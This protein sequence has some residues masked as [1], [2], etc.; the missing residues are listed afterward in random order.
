MSCACLSAILTAILLWGDHEPVPVSRPTVLIT[1]T[2]YAYT[3]FCKG[4]TDER[5]RYRDAVAAHGGLVLEVSPSMP[6]DE[7]DRRITAAD[8]ILVPGGGD[9]DPDFYHE[10]PHPKLGNVDEALDQLEFKV[11]KAA[12]DRRL[13]AL[14]ICRGM[15]VLNVFYG[16]TLIQDI[17][18][19][20]HGTN[21]VLH[22]YPKDT[23][24]R[25]EHPVTIAKDSLVFQLFGSERFVV[26]TYHHQA[27]E[28]LGKG[29]V[30]TA[31]ADDGV[32]EAI[33]LPGD[34]FVLGLQCHP[35]KVRCEDARF[36]APFRRLVKEAG[37]TRS[38]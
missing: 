32:V 12:E 10:T 4:Q 5:K 11:L 2:E 13:P 26:N 34:R 37:K 38:R 27:V 8:A 16:G 14:A 20:V 24:E 3:A 9:V 21:T 29:L 19:E 33:E 6:S 35:E 17:P 18:S 22:R 23:S 36:D 30:V 25:P 31:R 15:Q 1:Y 28:H 7:V